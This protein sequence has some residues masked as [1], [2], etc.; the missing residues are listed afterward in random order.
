ME[1]FDVALLPEL[2]VDAIA[3]VSLLLLSD[4]VGRDVLDSEQSFRSFSWVLFSSVSTFSDLPMFAAAE[5]CRGMT[6]EAFKFVDDDFS[7]SASKSMIK[8]PIP[9][10]KAVS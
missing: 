1:I 9:E 6:K 5:P 8:S 10:T 7:I 2:A 3:A 4:A